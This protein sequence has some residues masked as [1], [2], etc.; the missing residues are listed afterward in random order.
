MG[1]VTAID[2][3]TL[4]TQC[5]DPILND[6]HPYTANITE[7]TAEGSRSY[8]GTWHK[9]CVPDDVKFIIELEESYKEETDG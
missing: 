4:C 2:P 5:D 1:Q 6:P 8:A 9:A 7:H 3:N